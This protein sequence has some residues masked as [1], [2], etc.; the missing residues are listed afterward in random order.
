[1][2][3]KTCYVCKEERPEHLFPL[4]APELLHDFCQTCLDDLDAMGYQTKGLTVD[5]FQD[6]NTHAD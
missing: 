6:P 2:N 4:P 3:T 5:N 1:M